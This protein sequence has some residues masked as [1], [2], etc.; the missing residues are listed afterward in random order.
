MTL[1]TKEKL[2][3]LGFKKNNTICLIMN[4]S[5]ESAILY[6]ASLLIE[7]TVVP[8]DPNKGKKEIEEMLSLVKHDGIIFN[9][10]DLEV[11][12]NKIKSSIFTDILFEKRSSDYNELEIFAKID[13]D[14]LYLITFTSGTTGVP[15]GVMHSFANLVKSAFAFNKR[16]LFN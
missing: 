11:G 9:T 16:F 1:R 5:I 2:E 7:L 15:K 13:Y 4:N 14:R 3:H 10:P 6:F 12:N 8:I